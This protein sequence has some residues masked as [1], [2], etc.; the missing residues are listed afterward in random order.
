MIFQGECWMGVMKVVRRCAGTL[1]NW[2]LMMN[3][4]EA[5]T[6]GALGSGTG[7]KKL[8]STEDGVVPA[9]A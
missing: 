5:G 3:M 2:K 7:K 6:N 4:E 1:R 9:R 8:L